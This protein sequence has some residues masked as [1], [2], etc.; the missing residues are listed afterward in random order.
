MCTDVFNYTQIILWR[1]YYLA[2]SFEI[3]CRSS[4]GRCTK[5]LMHKSELRVTESIGIDLSLTPAGMIRVKRT[6]TSDNTHIDHT[7]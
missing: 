1:I 4:S 6:I 7:A 5:T 2:V 3:Q